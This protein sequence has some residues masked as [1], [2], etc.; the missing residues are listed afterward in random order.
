MMLLLREKRF[1]RFV[2]ALHFYSIERSGLQ[3]RGC[4]KNKG[5]TRIEFEWRRYLTMEN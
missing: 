3:V 2:T 5:A 1:D 4:R